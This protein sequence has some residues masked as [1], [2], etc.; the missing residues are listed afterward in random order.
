MEPVFSLVEDA[1][2]ELKLSLSGSGC[3]PGCLSLVADG[4]VHSL[5]ALLWYLL[6]ALF[7]EWAWQDSSLSLSFFFFSLSL[8]ISQFG[9]LS[10][11]CSLK[12]PSGHSAQDP[13][14]CSPC[15]PVQ[16]P[17]A[18]GGCECWELTL[19]M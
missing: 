8:A 3:P 18:G 4:P 7:Y 15:L 14:Q 5:L 12:L 17:L 10:Q 2:L 13:K 11:I 6:S 19:G 16:P 9:L 1:S